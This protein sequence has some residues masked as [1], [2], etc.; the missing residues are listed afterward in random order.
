MA[1]QLFLERR[2]TAQI[3]SVTRPL[4]GQQGLSSGGLPLIFEMLLLFKVTLPSTVQRQFHN[5]ERHRA[6]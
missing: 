6:A 3:I 5:A 4:L 1:P 2:K